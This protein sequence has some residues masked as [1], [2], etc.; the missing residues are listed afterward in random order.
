M[1]RQSFLTTIMQDLLILVSLMLLSKSAAS[2]LSNVS[3][4]IRQSLTR[5]QLREISSIHIS[6]LQAFVAG[7]L[8]KTD[9]KC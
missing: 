3:V 7:S 9:G 8:G 5:Q 6:S 2:A 4:F 1:N